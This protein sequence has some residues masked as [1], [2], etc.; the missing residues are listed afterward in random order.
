MGWTDR[1]DV[2]VNVGGFRMAWLPVSV[3]ACRWVAEHAELAARAPI[4]LEMNAE[5]H[6][7]ALLRAMCN[8]GLDVR[9][10]DAKLTYERGFEHDPTS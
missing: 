1:G 6:G 8:D 9:C 3:R 2:Q 7:E 5:P 10:G 4:N